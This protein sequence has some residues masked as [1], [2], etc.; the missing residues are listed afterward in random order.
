MENPG[1]AGQLTVRKA[2]VPDETAI[3]ALVLSERMNPNNL[4]YGNFMVAVQ[5]ERVVGAAQIRCH[6]DGTRELGS[7][8]IA[9]EHR[10]GT[11]AFALVDALLQSETRTVFAITGQALARNAAHWGFTTIDPRSA[12]ASIRFN[13]R[14]GRLGGLIS[15]LKGKA[16]KRLVVLRRAPKL[17]G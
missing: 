11:I 13:Y 10:G 17:P 14:I 7:L 16:P 8:M 1:P 12:P 5:G 6:A 15:I 2:G 9:P 4:D 3:K